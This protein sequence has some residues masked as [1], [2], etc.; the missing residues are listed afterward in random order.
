MARPTKFT[1]DRRKAIL[2]NLETGVSREVVSRAS[3][4]DPES[5]RK[6]IRK[7]EEETTGEYHQFASD[8]GKAETTAEINMVQ[9]LHNADDWR[10]AAWWLERRRPLDY[11]KN[12]NKPAPLK[13]ISIVD[14]M[15]EMM[16]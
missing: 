15:M 6:W 14:E 12:A 11:G 10:A 1:P 16:N 9:I 13:S 4:V 7:G 2:E 5:L 3:G 8:V